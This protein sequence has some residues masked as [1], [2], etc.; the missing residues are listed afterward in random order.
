[1]L[2]VNSLTVLFSSPIATKI[3]TVQLALENDNFQ[4]TILTELKWHD[5]SLTVYVIIL[6]SI[7]NRISRQKQSASHYKK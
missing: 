7:T 2:F 1:M 6:E 4:Q 3:H 5:F